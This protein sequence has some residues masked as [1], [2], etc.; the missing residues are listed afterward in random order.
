MSVTPRPKNKK[1]VCKYGTACYKL[2]C[3]DWHPGLTRAQQPVI[4]NH[5]ARQRRMRRR[6]EKKSERSKS[7]SAG[8][9]TKSTQSVRRCKMD[10]CSEN[11]TNN[12][13][14]VLVILYYSLCVDMLYS[15]TCILSRHTA[16]IAGLT[17]VN[18][19]IRRRT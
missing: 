11:N 13:D 6:Q 5:A 17:L 15:N 18:F 14:K 19:C 2:S 12:S 9:C 4:K 1:L 3:T 8:G 7:K 16:M 10:R